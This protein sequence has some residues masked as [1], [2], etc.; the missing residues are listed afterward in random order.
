MQKLHLFKKRA[1]ARSTARW[2]L[3]DKG[4]MSY[5]DALKKAIEVYEQFRVQQERDYISNFDVAMVD[6]LKGLGKP[7]NDDE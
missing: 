7:G 6:Y 4:R 5:E 2:V 3:E 1:T